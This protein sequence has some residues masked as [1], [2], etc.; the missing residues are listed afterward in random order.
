[1]LIGR[2]AKL[3]SPCNL[4][5]QLRVRGSII[6]LQLQLEVLL[7]RPQAKEHCVPHNCCFKDYTLR[8]N[9]TIVT[10]DFVPSVPKDCGELVL[11][12]FN[13]MYIFLMG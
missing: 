10:R 6:E 4:T 13:V 7:V 5:G 1:M 3:R 8:F 9:D 11:F 2:R 12:S